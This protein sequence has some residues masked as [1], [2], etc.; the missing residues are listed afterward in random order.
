MR[1]RLMPARVRLVLAGHC[2]VHRWRVK[3][4]TH[5]RPHLIGAGGWRRR[6]ASRRIAPWLVAMER[7]GA[8]LM[9]HD[10]AAHGVFQRLVELLRCLDSRAL[11]PDLEN[12]AFDHP[13]RSCRVTQL[14]AGILDE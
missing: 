2:R 1:G 10:V 7:R 14:L 11:V 3:C 5:V 6:V 12:R 13:R 4:G 8:A 9:A